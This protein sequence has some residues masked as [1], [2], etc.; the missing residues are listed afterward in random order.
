MK[1]FRCGFENKEDIKLCKKCGS[2]MFFKPVWYPTWK[3]HVRVLIII[4]VIIIVLFLGLNYFLK[5]YMRELP[6][7]I[8]PW[9]SK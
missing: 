9:L 3:W 7:D 8:T 6:A 2:E 4:F 1:C 5:P